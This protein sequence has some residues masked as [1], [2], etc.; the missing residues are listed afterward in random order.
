MPSDIAFT[1]S[2]TIRSLGFN[3][4]RISVTLLADLPTTTVVFLATAVV[5]VLAEATYTYNWSD[6]DYREQQIRI[7]S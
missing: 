1:P 3:P 5:P 2:V 4:L 7:L 6:P